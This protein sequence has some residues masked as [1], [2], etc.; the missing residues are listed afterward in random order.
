[1]SIKGARALVKVYTDLQ[2]AVE[3]VQSWFSVGLEPV[4][5]LVSLPCF[6]GI[7][8]RDSRSWRLMA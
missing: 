3:D 6:V 2:A 7:S 4:I 8:R 5:G 1:M